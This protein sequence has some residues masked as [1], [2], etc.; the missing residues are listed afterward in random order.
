MIGMI[1]LAV[2]AVL[3]FF[4]ITGGF[5]EKMGVA[6]WVAFLVVLAF[7]VAAV[8]PP[9]ITGSGVSFSYA[10]FFLPLL[11]GV[12]TLFALGPNGALLRALVGA[13][14][15]AG[16]VVASRVAIPPLTYRNAVGSILLIGFIGGTVAFIIGRS[17]LATVSSVLCGIVLGDFIA[18]MLFRFVTGMSDNLLQL[19]QNGIFDALTLAMLVGGIVL[20]LVDLV[21][22]TVRARRP[23]AM[24][25]QM[26]AAE[27]NAI[28]ASE[29]TALKEEDDLFEDYFN[30][31]I[32]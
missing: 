7:A 27:D 6:N 9:L 8:F 10:G 32:D 1:V 5:F 26:E 23:A 4:G 12:V 19:G 31:D 3:I 21:G 29:Y 16:I 2:I 28:P 11:L 18:A 22:H 15:I 24:A 20:E 25:V 30:D 13:M 17:R 14:A